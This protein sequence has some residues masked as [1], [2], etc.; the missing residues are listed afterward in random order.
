MSGEFGKYLLAT[1]FIV[2]VI[3]MFF[4]LN[5]ILPQAVDSFLKVMP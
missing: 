3:A 5:R 4:I 2:W 1:I